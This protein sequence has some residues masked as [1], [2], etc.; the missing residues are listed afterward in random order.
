M[1]YGAALAGGKSQRMGRDK[2]RLQLHGE[3]LLANAVQLL[4]SAGADTVLVS[5]PRQE[6]DAEYV[7][8]IEFGTALGGP[9]LALY[10]MLEY[11]SSKEGLKGQG[12]L[13]IP[14]DMPGLNAEVLQ[15]LI[16]EAGQEKAGHFEGEVFPCCFKLTEELHEILSQG[17]RDEKVAFKKGKD[18]LETQNQKQKRFSMKKIF[19][20][21]EAKVVPHEFNSEVFSNI[22][23]PDDWR[24]FKNHLIVN[25]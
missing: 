7:P 8:D 24:N 10:S 5:G 9:P 21:L 12:L 4:K 14:V 16:N 13:V 18:V 15:L 23:T 25:Q 3:T 19:T 11:V 20:L 22:N 1:F 17:I 2:T 6:P